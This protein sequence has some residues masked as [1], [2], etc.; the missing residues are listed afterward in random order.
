MEDINCIFCNIN[1][2]DVVIEENG[3]KG[4][5][6]PECGLIYISPR[7]SEEDILNMYG[8]DQA[9]ISAKSHISGAYGKKLYAK[10]NLKIIKKYKDKGTILE[11]GAGAGYFLDEARKI[12]YDVYG[13]EVNNIQSD[14]IRRN[15]EIPCEERPLGYSTFSS[16]KFDIIYHCDIL[17][18]FYN[19]LSE[20]KK[21]NNKLNENG[22]MVFET[23]NLGDV[24]KAFLKYIPVFQYPDHLFFYGENNLK[25][26]L[27][28]TGFE[29]MWI[30]RYSII[31][32]LIISRIFNKA[33]NFVKSGSEDKETDRVTNQG[34]VKV[35]K[36]IS[37]KTTK[38]KQ[39]Y[40]KHVKN[41]YL[42]LLYFIRYKIGH[43]AL[44]NERPQTIIV[45]AKKQ[46]MDAGFK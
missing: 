42:Y 45:V 28:L 36:L 18:H 35:R 30:H 26:L 6:C 27:E 4:R 1:S 19:P 16:M 14:F 39:G 38:F 21:I 40:K 37:K 15:L 17:S 3:Y 20:F 32:Q 9:N 24:N 29:L 13:I 2:I 44:K 43:F 11:L 7:P 23:G 31:P 22:I 12:G 41:I 46:T 34:D 25:K 10:H 8:H 33:F 5:K